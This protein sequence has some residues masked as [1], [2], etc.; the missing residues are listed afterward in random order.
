M[1]GGRGGTLGSVLP[2]LLFTHLGWP[3]FL[4]GLLGVMGGGGVLMLRGRYLERQLSESPASH[5]TAM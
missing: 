3:A 5:K 2:G 1:C 4:I